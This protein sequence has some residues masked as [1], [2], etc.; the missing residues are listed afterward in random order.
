MAADGADIATH[1]ACAGPRMHAV[2]VP[3]LRWVTPGAYRLLKRGN[4][5]AHDVTAPVTYDGTEES[6]T[7]DLAEKDS[8][9]LNFHFAGAQRDF[10]Q[11]VADRP[12]P[13]QAVTPM[14]TIDLPRLFEQ[15]DYQS[16]CTDESNGPAWCP[17]TS[18]LG[19]RT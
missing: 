19:T 18:Y 7:F 4:D 1:P 15:H 8:T 6:D 13:P 14:G 5:A 3:A 10:R 11:E 9:Q 17:E 2:P 16:V 12:V